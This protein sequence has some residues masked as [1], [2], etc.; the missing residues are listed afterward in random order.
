[1]LDSYQEKIDSSAL[2]IKWTRDVIFQ[3]TLVCI[4]IYIYKRCRH[5]KLR[6]WNPLFLYFSL[7][8]RCLINCIQ[9]HITNEPSSI[10]RKGLDERIVGFSLFF[11]S[12]F[13]GDKIWYGRAE[14]RG[15]TSS[16]GGNAFSKRMEGKKRKKRNREA[17]KLSSM[18]DPQRWPTADAKKPSTRENPCEKQFR[19]GKLRSTDSRISINRDT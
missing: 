1:M 7:F 2:I 12:S 5:S 16:E 8:V 19:L 6:V 11:S 17:F 18:I 9:N 10:M 14:F 3:R 4:Y 15:A 13:D